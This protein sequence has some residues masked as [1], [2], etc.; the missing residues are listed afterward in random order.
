MIVCLCQ[1][2]LVTQHVKGLSP[3]YPVATLTCGG[4]STEPAPQQGELQM[5]L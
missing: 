5:A 4:G 2:A 1:S 3:G